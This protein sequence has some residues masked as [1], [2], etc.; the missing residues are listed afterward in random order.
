VQHTVARLILI[1]VSLQPLLLV[2]WLIVWTSFCVKILRISAAKLKKWL[3]S[4]FA[5]FS[6]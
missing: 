2:L 4:N 3:H 1:D 5:D 6:K